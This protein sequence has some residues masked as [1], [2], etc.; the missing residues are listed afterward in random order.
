MFQK[1]VGRKTTESESLTILKTMFENVSFSIF[2]Q[3]LTPLWQI[4]FTKLQSNPSNSF[5]RGFILAFSAAVLANGPVAV[6][7]SISKLQSG[8]FEQVSLHIVASKAS[9]VLHAES[10]RSLCAAALTNLMFQY[11]PLLQD[12]QVCR[13][14]RTTLS[15]LIFALIIPQG[16]PPLPLLSTNHRSPLPAGSGVGRNPHGLCRPDRP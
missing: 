10:D 7:E 4:L 6:A 12:N 14:P 9:S 1:L 2:G 3:L 15:T 8:L 11:P 5:L 13:P 16:P